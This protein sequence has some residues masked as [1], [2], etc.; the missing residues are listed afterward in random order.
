MRFTS[1]KL[2][3]AACVFSIAVII[4]ERGD[5]RLGQKCCSTFLPMLLR[6]MG[7]G[8]ILFKRRSALCLSKRS[9]SDN[10]N[11]RVRLRTRVGLD[12]PPPI[13]D[14]RGESPLGLREDDSGETDPSTSSGSGDDLPDWAR[15]DASGKLNLEGIGSNRRVCL[16]WLNGVCT[17]GK[18]CPYIHRFDLK[19]MPD[20]NREAHEGEC[21]AEGCPF[22]H[23]KIG[24]VKGGGDGDENGEDGADFDKDD[25]TSKD[26]KPPCPYFFFGFC[27]HGDYCKLEHIYLSGPPPPPWKTINWFVEGKLPRRWHKYVAPI[28]NLPSDDD[29]T[30]V[31]WLTNYGGVNPDGTE[32]K[33]LELKK[34]A[35]AR[36]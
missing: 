25:R 12:S 19:K 32:F 13:F 15:E 31:D 16:N 27:P 34:P 17:R 3:V 9:K 26:S 24:K 10:Q 2:G 11:P 14:P 18:S 4:S 28:A 29:S 36:A 20:C 33:K 35:L 7:I 30:V 23:K 1:I 8:S 6:A 22:R 5:L 21:K